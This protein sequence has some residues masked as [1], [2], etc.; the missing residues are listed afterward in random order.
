MSEFTHGVLQR[1]GYAESGAM[2]TIAQNFQSEY[3]LRACLRL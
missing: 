2:P 3:P 1:I